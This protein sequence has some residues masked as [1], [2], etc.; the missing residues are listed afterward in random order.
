VL[1]KRSDHCPPSY[2]RRLTAPGCDPAHVSVDR[3]GGLLTVAGA[4][5]LPLG[6]LMNLRIYFERGWPAGSAGWPAR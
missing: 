6:V 1:G 3:A 5:I 2:M 4:A